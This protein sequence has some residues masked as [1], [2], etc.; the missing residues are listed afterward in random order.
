MAHQSEIGAGAAR[1]L[2]E[3]LAPPLFARDF[4]AV[5]R[6]HRVEPVLEPQGE[7]ETERYDK[8]GI[9]HQAEDAGDGSGVVS[10]GFLGA[11]GQ[12][13]A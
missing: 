11:A 2:E 9:A 4:G 3:S 12:E 5:C 8:T 7:V 6:E 10:H 1:E 13:S